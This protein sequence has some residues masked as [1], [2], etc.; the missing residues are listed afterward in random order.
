MHSYGL[1]THEHLDTGRDGLFDDVGRVGDLTPRSPRAPRFA[2]ARR[3]RR[4]APAIVPRKNQ[5][6]VPPSD[7]SEPRLVTRRRRDRHPL[8]QRPLLPHG[9]VE[10]RGGVPN[11]PRPI[12]GPRGPPRRRPPGRLGC[13]PHD[14]LLPG[15]VPQRH[16]RQ[17]R[18]HPVPRRQLHLHD[19]RLPQHRQPPLPSQR[20]HAGGPDARRRR[21]H[22]S[23]WMRAIAAACASFST[24][25]STTPDED[26][27]PSPPF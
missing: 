5:Q 27:G 22:A 14:P 26:T 6:R 9:L 12:R 2:L 18:P 25:S 3:A 24:A 23:W 4:H 1:G 17:P 19:A 8:P 10:R 20:F 16:H 13:S 11:F 15:R 21:R 7:D